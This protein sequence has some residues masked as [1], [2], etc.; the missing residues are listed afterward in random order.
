M[1]PSAHGLDHFLALAIRQW[2]LLTLLTLSLGGEGRAVEGLTEHL[3]VSKIP[4][5]LKFPFHSSFSRQRQPLGMSR[6]LARIGCTH[7]MN[8]ALHAVDNLS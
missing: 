1:A 5:E 2:G 4:S 8:S 7:G 3:E 6:A